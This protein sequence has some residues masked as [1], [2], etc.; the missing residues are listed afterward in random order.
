MPGFVLP[1]TVRRV[2]GP[3]AYYMLA[4]GYFRMHIA[5]HFDE[6]AVVCTDEEDEFPLRLIEQR[7]LAGVLDVV[8]EYRQHLRIRSGITG[9]YNLPRE[10]ARMEE[11]AADMLLN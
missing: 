1:S 11:I 6:Q 9:I 4:R 2:W 8:P 5:F 10:H 3:A 7:V